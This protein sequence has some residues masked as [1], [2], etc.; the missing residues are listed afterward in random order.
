[1]PTNDHGTRTRGLDLVA[2]AAIAAALIGLVFRFAA[3]GPVP[4]APSDAPRSVEVRSHGERLELPPAY[5][6]RLGQAVEQLAI[7]AWYADR[8]PRPEPAPEIQIL[9][10]YELPLPLELPTRERRTIEV[11]Q[12]ELSARAS[13]DD[14]W[15]VLFASTE[16]GTWFLAKYNGPLILDIFCAPELEPYAPAA[17]RSNCHLAP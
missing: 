11:R 7:G 2:R 17:L 8:S 14:G 4:A 13:L 6:A 3:A 10:T 1:M 15:P 9:V 5:L 16:G 12:L